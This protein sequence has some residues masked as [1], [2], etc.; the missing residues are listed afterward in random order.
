[1]YLKNLLIPFFLQFSHSKLKSNIEGLK[2]S[3]NNKFKLF[4]YGISLSSFIDGKF[5]KKV[6]KSSKSKFAKKQKSHT[7]ILTK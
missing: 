7:D 5:N 4:S 6:L 1:M 3:S 2:Y